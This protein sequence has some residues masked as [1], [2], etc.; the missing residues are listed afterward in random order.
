MPT[1]D[2]ELMAG[3]VKT[4]YESTEVYLPE[5]LRS[6]GRS[7]TITSLERV[8]HVAADAAQ[9]KASKDYGGCHG[10]IVYISSPQM[11]FEPELRWPR[12]QGALEPASMRF[13]EVW[14]LKESFALAWQNGV[15]VPGDIHTEF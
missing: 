10:L 15:A 7:L 8:C 13:T 14:I 1:P 3:Q 4:Q 12:V 2:F 11:S 5:V 9:K 6:T